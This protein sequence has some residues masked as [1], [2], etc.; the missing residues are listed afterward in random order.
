TT[1]LM[2]KKVSVI[3]G[4]KLTLKLF[5]VNRQEI[6][7]Q[8]LTTN[9]F[10]SINGNFV[11]PIGILNGMFSIKID[12]R[13]STIFNVE[14]YK[15]PKFEISFEPV[16]EEYQYGK[17]I[18]LKGKALSFS[19]VPISN[20]SVNYEIKKENIR[21]RYFWWYPVVN[22]NENSVLGET[23][24]N[25]KGEFVIKIDPKKNESLEGVQVDNFMVKATVTDINGETQTNE[26]S[27]TVASVSHYL[28]LSE[29]KT[30]YTTTEKLTVKIE[31]KN[32]NN[33]NL[34]KSFHAKLSK[35][36]Q[37][38]RV[39][40]DNFLGNLQ[41]KPLFSE[42]D[43]VQK[44]P[45]DL[46]SKEKS[47][48]KVE[49][50]IFDKSIEP[51]NNDQ[52][53]LQSKLVEGKYK[54]EIYNIEGKDTIKTQ[55]IF[56][57]Y[58]A[59]KLGSQ[60][61]FLKVIAPKTA[62]NQAEIKSGEKVKF[63][64]YS[65]VSLPNSIVNIFIQNGDG[66]ILEQ[67]S[68]KNGF[69]IYEL[70]LPKD[71]N[72]NMLN[73]QFQMVAYNDVQT[74]SI[75]IKITP[76]N[77]PL[78]IVTTVFR[79]KIE[80]GQKEK[81]AIK[82]IGNPNEKVNAEV[83]A[84]M[85]DKSLD[86]FIN[87]KIR[88]MDYFK[89]DNI[90]WNYA[91]QNNLSDKYY[92]K[93]IPY[94]DEKFVTLP[95]YNWFDG[96]IRQKYMKRMDSEAVALDAPVTN[97]VYRETDST[98]IEEVVVL[99]HSKSAI[100]TKEKVSDAK[101]NEDISNIPVRE[102]LKETA[103]FYPTLLTDKDGNV[104]FEFTSPEA[105]TQ[106]KLSFLAHTKDVRVAT[107]EK[108]VITQKEFSVTPNYP[109][110]LREG[111]ELVFKTKLS[112][113][114]DK[115]LSGEAQLIILDAYTNQDIS[116]KF[117]LDKTPKTFSIKSGETTSTQ[118]N[119]KVPTGTDAII[120]KTVAKAGNFSDGEQQAIA[121]LPNRMLV[122]EAVPVF[123]KQG[124]TKNFVLENL[125]N[126][127]STTVQNVST[128]LELTTNPI[129]EIIF[130][131]PS[132]KNDSQKSADVIFN[133]WFADVIANEIFQANPKVK[134]VFEEYQKKN[135]LQSNLSKNQ[136]LKQLLLDET[137]WVLDSKDETEQMQK[138]ASLLDANTMKNT[139]Q[140]DWEELKKLQNPDGGFS[141]MAGYPSSYTNSLYILKNLGKINLWLK[142][143]M[144]NYQSSE[145]KEM[146]D[147]LIKFVDNQLNRYIEIKKE[148]AWSNFALDYL[149]TRNY[150]EK[151]YPLSTQ[152]KKL[153]NW[154]ISQAPKAKITDFTFFGLHRA[155]LLFN[156]YGLKNLSKKLITYLKE[157]SV[158]TQT[159]GVYWKQN[160]NNWGWYNTKIENQAGAIE[161]FEK[162]GANENF[163]EELKI[164]L[165]TQKEVSHWDTSKGTASVIYTLLNSGKSWTNPISDQANISWGNQSLQPQLQ[166]TG[167]VKQTISSADINKN[168]ATVTV[169][170]DGPGIV[171]GGLFWQYYED[172]NKIKSSE[173][174]ISISKEL[175]KKIKTT[176]GEE[177][178]KISQKTPL[179]IGDK[180]TV[181]MILNSDRPM[182]FVHLKDMRAAGFEPT[183]VLSGY[184]WK[185][186]LGYY[187]VT[188]D[189]ST[190]FYIE[191]LPKGK[192][193]FEYDYIC[194]AAGTFSNGIATLQ[195]YYAPQMNA[196]SQGLQI[197]IEE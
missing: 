149:D 1:N 36:Q 177:L 85:Y 138:L 173:N 188:K 98:K 38:N 136:E 195:N 113:L 97:Q 83:L 30:D 178:Q 153:K 62:Y 33:Q 28:S 104:N 64:V 192:F 47:K 88:W 67:K 57:V 185:N 139:I 186:N 141:W 8:E 133:K 58:D 32:Y 71:E 6:V 53:E 134:T 11:L 52:Y 191:N 59:E 82:I 20:V 144:A 70:P 170:K 187:Q 158:E 72:I 168:L 100:S 160:L 90:I 145:Q 103:F 18:E 54:L 12:D 175:Y 162:L 60:K 166:A 22:Y 171:Q 119:L 37:P 120:I 128:T 115:V 25:E 23:K 197:K 131:L 63:L 61:P 161:A 163:V 190:N 51:T 112:N 46:Y 41:D 50:I 5:D 42:D 7:Q 182:E 148:N 44:F 167:Y 146:T 21:N 13:F 143:N 126:N 9:E 193:V 154:V 108:T 140:T 137:P 80:P 111:D 95:Y 129:W 179:K 26:T 194:N 102:N 105:L 89:K 66:T 76:E 10:G 43:F 94:L 34:K 69:L 159:Q 117:N 174:Y 4:K 81:W 176:N 19:G 127:T 99:G 124:Q 121:I 142:G 180:V 152:G 122:T 91:I 172:L 45:Y 78:Q 157:T 68:I 147:N 164:W 39:I 118:W 151:D 77:Q 55:Q 35:L 125:K 31:A 92:S 155:A 150:W 110:F 106:W 2:N 116:S 87:H 14:E 48:E 165:V 73:V 130:A 184:Q 114:S 15:R 123:V 132:L 107:L 75:K 40:R 49:S 181:R 183:N 79:D 109:R 189:A 93:R 65:G 169:K 96:S 86:K 16:K 3:S 29:T 196:H 17:T 74:Q 24:T 27:L 135:L 101:D 56:D 156:D 84:T